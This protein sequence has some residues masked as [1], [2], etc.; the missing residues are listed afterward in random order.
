M[1]T[2]ESS[3]A[4]VNTGGLFEVWSNGADDMLARHRHLGARDSTHLADHG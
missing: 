4:R 2:H 3:E 1:G